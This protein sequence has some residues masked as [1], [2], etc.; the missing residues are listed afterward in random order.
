MSSE[1]YWELHSANF[2]YLLQF[3][4]EN[5]SFLLPSMGQKPIP[6]IL[7]GIRTPTLDD[8]QHASPFHGKLLPQPQQ[9]VVLAG[10]PRFRPCHQPAQKMICMGMRT[11]LQYDL[12]EQES[13]RGEQNTPIDPSALELC[14]TA[15]Y[16]RLF[17]AVCNPGGDFA[18]AKEPNEVKLMTQNFRWLTKCA[19]SGATLMGPFHRHSL[20]RIS[21]PASSPL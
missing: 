6:P 19:A 1:K 16:L 7:Y 10:C 11:P 20:L 12:Q 14:V 17:D 21:S 3:N 18:G 15:S 4:F 8:P 2:L 13:S 9:Y 5:I